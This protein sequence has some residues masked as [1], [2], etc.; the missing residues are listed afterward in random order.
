MF[1]SSVSSSSAGGETANTS[2]P[3][4]TFISLR[5]LI[6]KQ[7]ENF[8][9]NTK[10]PI[11][12]NF[13]TV[14]VYPI[15]LTDNLSSFGC[16]DFRIVDYWIRHNNFH[17]DYRYCWVLTTDQ[18]RCLGDC[19]DRNLF[20]SHCQ[21]ADSVDYFGLNF[22][23]HIS[24]RRSDLGSLCDLLYCSNSCLWMCLIIFDDF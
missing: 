20:Y 11:L 16:Y 21:V 22:E 6:D 15:K 2:Q 19:W 7:K 3:F 18:G 24:I 9:F 5:N 8:F 1:E 4:V 17:S 10:S 13:Q 23:A 14:T 12:D